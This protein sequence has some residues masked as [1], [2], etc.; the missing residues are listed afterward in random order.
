MSGKSN[1]FLPRLHRW[2]RGARRAR[3]TF[4]RAQP[5]VRIVG[6]VAILLAVVPLANLVYQVIR[7]PTELFVFIGHRLDKEPPETWRQ[8]G[9][10]FR[11]YS[12]HHHARAI[13]RAGAGREFR[14]SG[15]SHLLALAMEPQSVRDLPARLQCRR[16]LPDH[17][18]RL[19]RGRE[20]LYPG[21][22]GHGDRL[23]VREP[24]YPRDPEPCHR[25][26]VGVS[27]PMSRRFLPARAM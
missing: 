20:V 1:R 15:G 24:L 19:R 2:R 17:R 16:S 21:Q 27:G 12:T 11:T 26:G 25:A 6:V 7:K 5:M 14:Q 22:C 9:A 10:L 4:A 13:G 18:W 3:R 8:Y 23:R